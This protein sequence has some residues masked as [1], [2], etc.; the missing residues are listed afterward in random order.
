MITLITQRGQN[1]QNFTFNF[2][3]I[4]FENPILWRHKIQTLLQQ[5]HGTAKLL[6]FSKRKKKDNNQFFKIIDTFI[7]SFIFIFIL[8]NC[9]EFI[10]VNQFKDQNQ[11]WLHLL[12]NDK[13]PR[14]MRKVSSVSGL[15]WCCYYLITGSLL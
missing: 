11:N 10:C 12:V 6:L 3:C 2:L 9:Y 14:M 5:Y 8:L 1:Y 7:R 4:L 15:K 13:H